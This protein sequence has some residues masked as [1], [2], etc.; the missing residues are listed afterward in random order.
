MTIVVVGGRAPHGRRI[1][2]RFVRVTTT[3]ET[4]L[5][6]PEAAEALGVST[7]TFLKWV[8]EPAHEDV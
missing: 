1:W 6:V 3:P 7:P 5:S 8:K 4:W 2:A